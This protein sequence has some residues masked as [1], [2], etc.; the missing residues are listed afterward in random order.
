MLSRDQLRQRSVETT[1]GD[2]DVPTH[3]VA[4]ANAQLQQRSFGD[5]RI[6]MIDRQRGLDEDA[7]FRDKDKLQQS[8]TSTAV[9]S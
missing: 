2:E 9:I 6:C 4:E 5:M 7:R 3:P 1:D 8:P